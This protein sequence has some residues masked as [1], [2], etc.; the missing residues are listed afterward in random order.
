MNAEYEMNERRKERNSRSF[1]L[2]F[3]MSRKMKQAKEDDC[4]VRAGDVM[5]SQN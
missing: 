5:I 1:I 4:N 3:G 2:Q